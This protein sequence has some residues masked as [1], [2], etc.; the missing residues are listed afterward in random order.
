MVRDNGVE[1]MFD[2]FYRG[3]FHQVTH[4]PTNSFRKELSVNTEK[5]KNSFA[6]WIAMTFL[7]SRTTDILV[8]VRDFA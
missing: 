4:I 6:V 8:C 5:P 2:I 1:M 3:R 7:L